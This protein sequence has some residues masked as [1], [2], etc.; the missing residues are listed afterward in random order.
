MKATQ[1]L[2]TLETFTQQTER[3][4]VE[5]LAC[6]VGASATTDENGTTHATV[7]FRIGGILKD[8]VTINMP[9]GP[10]T[11]TIGS[12]SDMTAFQIVTQNIGENGV[13]GI[14]KINNQTKFFAFK[15]NGITQKNIGE[16]FSDLSQQMK[17]A[18]WPDCK[19][20]A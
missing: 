2:S 14:M 19:T 5:P 20:D 3:I 17:H 16:I 15:N 1:L 9:S 11:Q 12:M 7:F 18:F 8:G 13:H 10:V 4:L 6:D